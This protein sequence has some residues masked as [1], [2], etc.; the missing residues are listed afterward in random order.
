MATVPK[1]SWTTP[2]SLL[3]TEEQA[4]LFREAFAQHFPQLSQPAPKDL[5]PDQRGFIIGGL[6]L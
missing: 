5:G 6:R 4:R 3:P 2:V 1:Q